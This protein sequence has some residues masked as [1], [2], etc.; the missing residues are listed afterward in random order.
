M[1]VWDNDGDAIAVYGPWSSD[2]IQRWGL[3]RV[4]G[5]MYFVDDCSINS[6]MHFELMGADDSGREDWDSIMGLQF[7]NNIVD[8]DEELTQFFLG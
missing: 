3:S 2:G 4:L 6:P 7:I 1:R 5:I 8:V